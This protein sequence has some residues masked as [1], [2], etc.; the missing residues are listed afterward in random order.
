M[1]DTFRE[2]AGEVCGAR[3]CTDPPKLTNATDEYDHKLVIRLLSIYV[4]TGVFAVLLIIVLL[5]RL[6][7]ALDRR[8]EQ[9]SGVSLLIA[10][11]KHLKDK[12]MLLVLPLT[13]FSGLEQAFTFGDYTAVIYLFVC[14]FMFFIICYN[15]LAIKFEFE[16]F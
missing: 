8:K 5:D 7:G 12:R 6:T 11:L 3:F 10:T 13:M 4:G 1:E 2:N 14:L 16:R 9:E 15:I